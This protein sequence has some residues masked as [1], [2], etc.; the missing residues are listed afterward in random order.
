MTVNLEIPKPPS[1]KKGDYFKKIEAM[2]LNTPKLIGFG[3]SNADTFNTAC[4]YANGA[5]IGSAFIKTLTT[6][7]TKLKTT[8]HNFIKPLK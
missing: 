6:A 5:I 4:N 2:K 8:I 7:T 3:I 1:I